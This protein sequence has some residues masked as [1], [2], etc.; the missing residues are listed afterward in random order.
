MPSFKH[1]RRECLRHGIGSTAMLAVGSSV[2][3]SLAQ[4]ALTSEPKKQNERV[5]VVLELNGGNDGLNTIVPYADDVYY[6]SRPQLNIPKD[7]VLNINDHVGMHSAT[8][9]L[10][11]M[12]EDQ[13]L[14]IVQGVGYPN[15]VRSHFRSHSIWSSADL[16]ANS[17]TQGWLSRLVDTL[18]RSSKL[19]APAIQVSGGS[20]AQSLTGG[21]VHSPAFESIEGLKRR[22]G[23]PLDANP[24][25]QRSDL[26]FVLNHPRPEFDLPLRY[27]QETM[28]NSFSSSDKLSQ[29]LSHV[30][31]EATYPGSDLARQLRMIAQ[32][33]KANLKTHIYYVRLS[34]FD[35]HAKQRFDH[36]LLLRTFSSAVS[37]F[38]DDLTRA[39]EAD[40]VVMLVFSEFGRR[41]KENYQGGTDHGTA[42]PVFLAGPAVKAGIHG[43]PPDLQ[44]L[45]DSGDPKFDIDFRS[46]YASLL[47]D[48]FRIDNNDIL[49]DDTA[50]YPAVKSVIG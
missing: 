25:K 7:S 35:T 28:T 11:E 4:T 31:D 38:F 50:P 42:G 14:S 30:K 18:P 5:L 24:S 13:T 1:T 20:V 34:G 41:L 29:I 26:E 19:D 12:L 10:R 27:V 37:A 33:I 9:E 44:N 45:D 49:P 32:L 48:W 15:P 46:I 17:S 40:R 36:P 3:G 21:T 6:R 8:K 22:L 16:R 43:N 39:N 47:K 23:V 2:P